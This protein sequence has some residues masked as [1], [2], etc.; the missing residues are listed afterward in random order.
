MKKKALITGI[1]GQDGA[2]LAKYLI[3]KNN[4]LMMNELISQ[5]L[6]KN[7]N[8]FSYPIYENWI[9]IGNKGDFYNYR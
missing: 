4:K 9:D 2:Y 7:K 8:V 6:K 5:Q 3:K 1:S